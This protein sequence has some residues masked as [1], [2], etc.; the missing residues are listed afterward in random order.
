MLDAAPTIVEELDGTTT[1]YHDVP[2]GGDRI[3]RLLRDLFTEHWARITV[4]P[5]IEGAA[6]EVRFAGPPALSMLDGY[7]TVDAGGWHFHLCVADTPAGG[8][9]EMARVRRVAR[10][11]FFR[12]TGGTCSP[13]SY[14][15]RLWNGRGEQM[16]TVFFPNPFFD[17]T[18]QRRPVPDPGA[19]ALWDDF[20]RRYAG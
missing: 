12:S 14:G 5:I 2:V 1:E 3:E 17:D 4:G 15:L 18:G 16:V 20:R 13:E 11:A 8:R 7:L 9:P 10:A 6:W 19:T